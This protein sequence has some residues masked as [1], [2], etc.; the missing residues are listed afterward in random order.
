M[1]AVACKGRQGEVFKGVLAIISGSLLLAG[2]LHWRVLL[3]LLH[4]ICPAYNMRVLLLLQAASA[5]P[6]AETPKMGPPSYASPH[7][8]SGAHEHHSPDRIEPTA[9]QQGCALWCL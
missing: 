1:I 5:H 6:Q 3:L 9:I 4:T 2:S 8:L 7:G